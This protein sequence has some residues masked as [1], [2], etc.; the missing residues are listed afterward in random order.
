LGRNDEVKTI[1]PSAKH[2]VGL[3]PEKSVKFDEAMA[4]IEPFYMK[5][6]VPT[7]SKKNIL[8]G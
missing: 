4:Q 1:S 8:N 5:E 6:F 2:F 7:E 3:L